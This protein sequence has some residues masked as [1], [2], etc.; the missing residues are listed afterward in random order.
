MR[1]LKYI[2][3]ILSTVYL[4]AAL[5][6]IRAASGTAAGIRISHLDDF[7]RI[8]AL[9][10]ALV[11][12][13]FAYGI[14]TKARITWKAGFV[15]LTISY[16]FSAVAAV[17]ATYHVALTPSFSTFWLPAGLVALG[18]GAVTVYWALW[19]RRQRSY[20]Q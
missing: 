20:F 6:G 9:G 15:L 2:C 3:L 1:L 12:A 17:R 18:G 14:H 13:L 19:W 5:I 10:A 11:L 8:E 7:G 4:G 16:I